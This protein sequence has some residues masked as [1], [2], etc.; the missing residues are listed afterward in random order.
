MVWAII[1]ISMIYYSS[2]RWLKPAEYACQL[3]YFILTSGVDPRALNIIYRDLSYEKTPW[4][5]SLWEITA[6][7]GCL[8]I[9]HSISQSHRLNIVALHIYESWEVYYNLSK[10][11]QEYIIPCSKKNVAAVFILMSHWLPSNCV[12]PQC[13][14]E[15]YLNYGYKS[16]VMLWYLQWEH[17]C[18]IVACIFCFNGYQIYHVQ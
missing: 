17:T 10:Q 4:M 7:K 5:D 13:K 8:Y 12:L 6:K 14:H 1:L 18:F 3:W 9:K 2:K 11:M 16:V 15:V